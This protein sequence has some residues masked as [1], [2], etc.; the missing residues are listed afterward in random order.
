MKFD[1]ERL[2]KLL[3]AIYRIRDGEQGEPL[4]ALIVVLA[5]QIGVLEEDLA[6]LYDD[7][8]VETC[9][10]WVL[11]YVGDLI[12]VRGLRGI[13]QAQLNP[14]AEVA[15]TIGYRRRKGTAAVLEQLARD[16]TGWPAR[17]VEF[18]Q[19]LATTQYLNHRRPENRSFL[20]VSTTGRVERLASHA[21]VPRGA[22]RLER[23]G[24]PFEHLDGSKDLP[25]TVDVRR[26]ASGRG[27]YNIPNVGIFL[28]RLGAYS[29]TR[30]PAVPAAPADRRR[31]LFNPLG[32]NTPLFNLPLTE[33]EFTHLAEPVNVPARISRRVLNNDL[34][35]YYAPGRSLLLARPGGTAGDEPVPI[36]AGQIRVCDLS[37]LKDATGW[38]HLPR[39]KDTVAVDPVLGRIAFPADEAKLPLATWHY[40]FSADLGGGEYERGG[41]FEVGLELVLQVANTRPAPFSTIQAALDELGS[42]NGVV[43]II[44]SGRYAEDLTLA[45]GG[46]RLELRARNGSRPTLVLGG[47][48]T[49]SGAAAGSLTLNG[50]LITGASLAADGGLGRLSLR[51]CTLVPGLALDT[52]GKPTSPGPPSLV[53]SSTTQVEIDHCVTGGLRVGEGVR[54][55]IAN[56]IVDATAETGVAYAATGKDGPGGPLR[57]VNGTVIGKVYARVL[58]LASNTIFLAALA[59]KDSWPVPVLVQRRQQGCVRFSY[60]PPGSRVPQRF[61][62]QPARSTDAARLRPVLTSRHYGDPEYCQLSPHCA[63][64]IRRGAD[65]EGEMGAFHDL[66]QP[67]REAQLRSRLEEYLRFGLEAGVFYVT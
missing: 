13:S 43:E 47:P 27:R 22:V 54:V 65:D 15:N 42:R 48:W 55:R 64:E 62:C 45:G 63:V 9:A 24:S 34:T 14:R 5:E 7:Q 46:Q 52:D 21:G 4:K 18:F 38:A 2:Y 19:L 26:I 23:L 3:P 51:H 61:R 56:S 44:D 66:Y 67:Q 36:P 32:N 11:P 31:F 40:G 8:F 60:V 25:H 17:A 49:L 10:P 33:D 57:V 1:A 30:S 41:S 35:S 39:E 58:E 59:K 50:L 53:V 28:W 12:G 37:D 29:L 6:Q 20:A 16:I